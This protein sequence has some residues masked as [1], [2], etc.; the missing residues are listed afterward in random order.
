MR[1]S[2]SWQQGAYVNLSF[3]QGPFVI[4]VQSLGLFQDRSREIEE[5]MINFRSKPFLSP[6]DGGLI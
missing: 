2:N 4:P 1:Y 6:L 3:P 5:R